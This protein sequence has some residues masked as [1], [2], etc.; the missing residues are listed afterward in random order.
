MGMGRPRV[1]LGIPPHLADLELWGR[2]VGGEWWALVV[3]SVQVTPPDGTH[4]VPTGCA[5]WVPGLHVEQPLQPVDYLQVRRMQLP[6]EP[7]NGPRRSTV[8]ARTGAATTSVSLSAPS[9]SYR[10]RPAGCGGWAARTADPTRKTGW[11]G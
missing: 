3:W 10:P 8:P 1:R 9:R 5:A 6:A 4:P 7:P 2:D 11:A